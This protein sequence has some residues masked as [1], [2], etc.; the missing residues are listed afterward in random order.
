MKIIFR[1]LL[2]F[3]FFSTFSFPSWHFN[4]AFNKY[5]FEIVKTNEKLK[6]PLWKKMAIF[7]SCSRTA[8]IHKETE[9][10]RETIR[11]TLSSTLKSNFRAYT[12]SAEKK[13]Q[14]QSIFDLALFVLFPPNS[15]ILFF[16]SFINQWQLLSS[17]NQNTWRKF[18]WK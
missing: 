9:I 5:N 13:S 4:Y 8:N 10:A 18:Q 7:S 12:L 11:F 17:E 16:L 3:L 6:V 1:S 2:S 15:M 14:K